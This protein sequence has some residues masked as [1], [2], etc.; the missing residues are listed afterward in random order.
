MPQLAIGTE[1]IIDLQEYAPKSWLNQRIGFIEEA[2]TMFD[3]FPVTVYKVK[4]TDNNP[5][6][7]LAE[8]EIRPYEEI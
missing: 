7:I 3:N 5:A 2:F 8:W 6:I 1:V 4:V